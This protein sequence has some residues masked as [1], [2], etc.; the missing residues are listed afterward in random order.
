MA[1]PRL[2]RF[3]HVLG[4]LQRARSSDMDRNMDSL[5]SK[6]KKWNMESVHFDLLIGNKVVNGMTTGATGDSEST[7]S[8]TVPSCQSLTSPCVSLFGGQC[9]VQL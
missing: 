5:R 8:R 4:H 6:Q 2:C 9:A 1:L 7:A 3:P